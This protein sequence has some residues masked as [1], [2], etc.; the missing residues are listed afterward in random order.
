MSLCVTL[1]F[2]SLRFIFW[3]FTKTCLLERM[4]FYPSLLNI[5]LTSKLWIT[6]TIT[7]K[8]WLYISFT[9]YLKLDYSFKSIIID[10]L[11]LARRKIIFFRRQTTNLC[12]IL[13]LQLS[14]LLLPMPTLF[15]FIWSDLCLYFHQIRDLKVEHLFP[16]QFV[17]LNFFI[18]LHSFLLL[19]IFFIVTCLICRDLRPVFWSTSLSFTYIKNRK[20][21]RIFVDI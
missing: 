12:F 6:R 4:S 7:F 11:W 21:W 10:E 9:W 19:N 20:Y 18:F 8:A 5:W 17:F 2:P 13:P 3:Y 1:T 16:P 15:D 14:L